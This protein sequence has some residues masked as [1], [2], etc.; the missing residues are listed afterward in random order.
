MITKKND[1]R[2]YWTH[3]LVIDDSFLRINY[4]HA[5]E[6]PYNVF[7]RMKLSVIPESQIIFYILKVL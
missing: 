2:K 4:I 7:D 3:T 5:S 1:R 6:I